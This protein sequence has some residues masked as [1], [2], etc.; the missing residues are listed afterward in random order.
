MSEVSRVERWEPSYQ[1]GCEVCGM[2]PIVTGLCGGRVVYDGGLCGPC[3]WGESDADDPTTWND[4]G[5]GRG[6]D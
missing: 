3:T 6:H 2:K 1:R 4:D 5:E